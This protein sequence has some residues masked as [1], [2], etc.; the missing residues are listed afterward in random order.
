MKR[1]L[2][3]LLVA[4]VAPVLFA[5]GDR[6]I[7]LTQDGTLYTASSEEVANDPGNGRQ[8]VLSI[9]QGDKVVATTVPNSVTYAF[10]A[11][12]ALAYDAVSNTVFVIWI[13]MPSLMSS[14][15]LVAAYH[16]GQ[17]ADPVSIDNQPFHVRRGLRIAVRRYVGASEDDPMKEVP[18]L[19][20]HAVWWEQT[21]QG[22]TARYALVAIENGAVSNI[23]VH[24]LNEFVTPSDPFTVD[25]KFNYEILKHPA[26]IDTGSRSSVDVVFGNI[27]TR[28]F[29]R[30][31]LRPVAQT[32]IHIPVGHSGDSPTFIGAPDS[33]T[34]QWSG[35]YST[36]G[37]GQDSSLIFY[38]VSDDRVGYV[39]YS[40]GSWSAAKTLPLGDKLSADAAVAALSRMISGN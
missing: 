31:T 33:L 36:M 1:V 15:V 17:W 24:D 22:E 7:L 25:P 5:Q 11:S 8:V 9:R 26:I 21:G 10:D 18:A 16:D 20:L 37:S 34:A 13:K 32:R 2:I 29:N 38:A 6:D 19:V 40:Q 4:L 3:A 28:G 39:M 14:E 23:E 35:K 27:V 12:P 30:I